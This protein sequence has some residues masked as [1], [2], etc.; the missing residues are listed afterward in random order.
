LPLLPHTSGIATAQTF[1]SKPVRIL[2]PQAPGGASDALARIIGQK[3]SERWRQPVV[4]ENRAGAGG[5]IGTDVVAKSAPDGYTLLLAYAGTHAVNASLYKN[6]PFDPVK[7]FSAAA[8]LATVP[9]VLAVNTE[10]GPKQTYGIVRGATRATK[11]CAKAIGRHRPITVI[12][13]GH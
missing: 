9:F 2:V 8:T 12:E 1:P 11:G 4:V 7:D 10:S 13:T 5:V 6:L 3:L